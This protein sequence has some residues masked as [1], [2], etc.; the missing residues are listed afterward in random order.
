MQ[1][2]ASGSGCTRRVASA[3]TSFACWRAVAAASLQF[4]DVHLGQKSV[5]GLEDGGTVGNESLVEVHQADEFPKFTQ[6]RGLGEVLNGL[7]FVL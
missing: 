1:V 2:G 7:H 5:Q 4:R 3:R 6:G